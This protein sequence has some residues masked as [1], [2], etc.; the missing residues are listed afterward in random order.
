MKRYFTILIAIIALAGV[1]A[2]TLAYE[3]LRR[4]MAGISSE[5]A[6]MP[7]LPP[8]NHEHFEARLS[9]IRS[10]LSRAKSPVIILGDSI[11]ESATFPNDV[12]GHDIIN[13]GVGGV[14]I[15]FF[16]RYAEIIARE[17]EASLIVLA[18]GINDATVFARPGHVDTFRQAYQATLQSIPGP[19]AVVTITPSTSPSIDPELV[20]QFNAVIR[21]TGQPLIDV[22]KRIEAGMTVDGI[23]LNAA[24][25]AIWTRAFIEGIGLAVGCEHS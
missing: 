20:E 17:K 2:L 8:M 1:V 6:R 13:A 25:Y 3:K 11:V 5:L 7:T 23:H 21:D 22:N 18:V 19:F 12:C 14:G 10:Q 15:G 16:T 9:I 4:Q 24:G